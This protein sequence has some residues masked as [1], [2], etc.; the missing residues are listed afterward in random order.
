[1]LLRFV[2]KHAA[3]LAAL[4]VALI[5]LVVLAAACGDDEPTGEC[6]VAQDGSLVPAGCDV[7]DGPP[8]DDGPPVD[9][10][11]DEPEE[12]ATSAGLFAVRCGFCHA[13]DGLSVGAVGPDLTQIGGR[14]DADYIVES[15]LDPDAV[16]AEGCP[17]GPCP[18]GVMP[19][20]FGDALSD[21]ELDGLVAFLVAKQ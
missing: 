4:L 9:D 12:P 1:M 21:E 18:S 2:P 15:I 5:A 13:I 11:P 8:I 19:Q 6:R 7:D 16:I 3:P 17:S 20:N 10:G 14:A